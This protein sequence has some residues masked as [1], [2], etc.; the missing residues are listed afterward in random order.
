MSLPYPH[1]ELERRWQ[2]QWAADRAHE[3]DPDKVDLARKL[4]NLVEFPYPSAEGLHIGHALTYCGA[5]VWGRYQRRR[6]RRVFQPIGFDAFGINAE[7]FA[8]QVGE[9]PRELMRRTTESYRRQLQSLGCAWSW[10]AVL[11]T[12]DPA[13]FRWTQ[14]VFLRLY[15]AGLAYRAEAPVPWCPSCQTVLAREQIEGI[16]ASADID[17]GQGVC[18][19]CGTPVEQ[20][21]MRQWFLR[22]TAYANRLRAGLG[23][24]DWPAKAKNR[25]RAW[26]GGLHDWLISRQRYW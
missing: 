2:R 22:I 5:D 19:R 7:N 18:E 6:G 15:D 14:W 4:Y 12:D 8:L 25:Q 23:A 16:D 9:H 21:T 10:D 3:V 26:I 13:Y 17:Q 20:R 24:L 1:A 11:S